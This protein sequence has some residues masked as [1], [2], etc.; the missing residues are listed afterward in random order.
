MT[1]GCRLNSYDDYLA[2]FV[3]LHQF[4]PFLKCFKWTWLFRQILD[5]AS[6]NLRD[7]VSSPTVKVLVPA[8]EQ[9]RER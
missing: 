9:S 2:E 7:I 3:L 1:C 5:G 8:H 4:F 6:I